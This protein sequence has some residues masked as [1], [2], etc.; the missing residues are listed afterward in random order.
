MSRTKIR[1]PSPSQLPRLAECIRY[2]PTEYVEGGN[3]A[4]IEGIMLH[5]ICEQMIQQ[6]IENWDEWINTD[7][8]IPES[9][10]HLIQSC[11]EQIKGLFLIGLPVLPKEMHLKDAPEGLF[12]VAECQVEPF[13][14]RR[15]FIDLLARTDKNHAVVLDYKFGRNDNDFDLQIGSYIKAVMERYPEITH[16]TAKIVAPRLHTADEATDVIWTRE[17]VYGA[18]TQ[19]V[20]SLVEGFNDDFGSGT[21]CQFCAT[22]DGNGRCP[23]QSREVGRI[24]LSLDQANTQWLTHPAT[25]EERSRRR[26]VMAIMDAWIEGVK[27]DDKEYLLNKQAEGL[28]VE[29]CLPGYK[30]SMRR[31]KT[32]LDLEKLADI[33]RAL[34]EGL[35]VSPDVMLDMCHPSKERIVEHL[36]L[37]RGMTVD[38]AAKTYMSLVKNFLKD[39]APFPVMSRAVRTGLPAGAGLITESNAPNQ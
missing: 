34:L 27:A 2:R 10:R 13:P 19:R 3:E 7:P 14:G 11:A 16:M 28:S 6:P 33:N 1:Y 20:A 23:W 31:G 18:F 37:T 12:I 30:V 17:F 29:S 38:A 22:C 4:A 5:G 25:A 39:G 36:R 32:T 24:S 8:Q 21:P 15:G 26:D 9:H 35:G